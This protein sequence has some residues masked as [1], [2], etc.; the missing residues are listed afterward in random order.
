VPVPLQLSVEDMDLT[1]KDEIAPTPLKSIAS[2]VH[3]PEADMILPAGQ[4][5]TIPFSVTIPGHL[6]LGGYYGIIYLHPFSRTVAPQ[7]ISS[8]IGVFIL[9]SI[10]VQ[11][12]PLNKIYLLNPRFSA[13]IYEGRE[14]QIQ[15]SVKNTALNHFSAKPFVRITS[16]FGKTQDV[17]LEE[18]IIFPGRTRQW[19]VP[20]TLSSYPSFL[21]RAD[22][23]VSV[24]GGI[25]QKTRLYFIAF[26]LLKLLI[27]IALVVV[28]G[29][30]IIN[31]RKIRDALRIMI[32]G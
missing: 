12:I 23:M 26:P 31:R 7:D 2:W 21:Y 11:E 29:M 14:T 4:E 15:F 27:L 16:L 19:T 3:F 30:I 25:Q 28:G 1:Q 22:L 10:G 17:P 20:I 5:R 24:G 32:H 13:P 18:K 6:P 8:K 9:G